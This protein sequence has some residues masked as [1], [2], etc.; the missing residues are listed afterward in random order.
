MCGKDL[1]GLTKKELGTRFLISVGISLGSI[2]ALLT[3]NNA[4]LTARTQWEKGHNP[5]SDSDR[6]RVKLTQN[7][8]PTHTIL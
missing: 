6:R 8:I 3:A 7:L 1:L 4:L 5:R 2:N